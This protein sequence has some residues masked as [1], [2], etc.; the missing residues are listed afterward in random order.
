MSGSKK[1]NKKTII[2]NSNEGSFIEVD[3]RYPEKLQEFHN[4]LPFLPER[5]T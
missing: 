4:D 3:A 5:V 1:L 2:K